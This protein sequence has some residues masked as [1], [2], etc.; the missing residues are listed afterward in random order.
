[1]SE[2]GSHA[3]ARQALKLALAEPGPEIAQS[4]T[5]G[6]REFSATVAAAAFARVSRVDASGGA[7]AGGAYLLRAKERYNARV[8]AGAKDFRAAISSVKA[9]NA[10]AMSAYFGGESYQDLCSAG[11]LLSNAFRSNSTQSPDKIPQVKKF[12]AFQKEADAVVA[13]LKKRKTTEAQEAYARALEA[14][15][16]YMQSVGLQVPA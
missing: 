14:L 10:E 12:K 15:D 8:E 2:S 7:T 5:L 4:V 3:R 1:M 9:G 16:T 13:A 11:F 6:R